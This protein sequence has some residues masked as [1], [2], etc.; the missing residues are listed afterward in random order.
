[1]EAL[2]AQSGIGFT[3][4]PINSTQGF[5][6]SFRFFFDGRTYHFN[7]Y[8]NAAAEILEARPE[9]LDVP[10]EAAF[11]VVRVE[12]ELDDGAREI[13]FLSK[14]V[15]HLEYEV[16]N[17]KLLFSDQRVARDNINGQGE[18]G[19]HVVGGIARRWA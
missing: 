5:P 16:E 9:F 15:P 4:L 2:I 7:L 6:Q 17:I 18:H 11:L 1:M 8:V 10:T 19:T 13:I 12:R 14:I 3:P